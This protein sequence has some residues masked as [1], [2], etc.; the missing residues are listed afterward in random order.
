MLKIKKH[1]SLQPLIDGFKARFADI[2]KNDTRRQ[3][4]VEYSKLDTS[5][6]GLACMFYKSSD[7]LS[8]QERMKK[9]YYKDNLETQFGVSQAPKDNQMRTILG[10][11]DAKAFSPVYKD[12]LNRLQRS[13]ELSKFK[14]GNKYLVALDA[15]QYYSSSKI[16]CS[17]CLTKTDKK[18]NI[19][20]Y[21]HSALQPIICHPDQKQILPMMP[22]DIKN[23]DGSKKQDCEIN[24]AKRLLPKLRNSHPKMDFVWLAD[25]IYATD[26]FISSILEAKEDFIFRIKQGDHKYLYEYIK[27]SEHQSYRYISDKSTIVHHYYQDVPL[28]KSSDIKVNVIKAY[29]I[30]KDK[31][32]KQSSNLIGVWATN[33]QLDDE[34]IYQVTRA[35]RTRWKI[36]NEC[37]NALK[38]NGY[39]LTHNWGHVKGESFAIYNL[40]MLA[41]YIHQILELTDYLF[42]KC[43]EIS[44]TFKNLWTDLNY[45][46]KYYLFESWEHMLCFHLERNEYPP[47]Q[48]V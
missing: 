3:E 17:C 31:D 34:N 36:E 5:L 25:S 26:P 43:R 18:G 28:N 37:F 32:G 24:A 39:E 29:S 9:K 1:L 10:S 40:I 11:I 41:F 47:P 38:N 13:K 4:S 22:E 12:Y 48:I 35:A 19:T 27:T 21:S 44:R 2:D 14:F 33:I 6:A 23:S 15:T 7:M 42:K 20:N 16:S 30:T 46:F 45:H 8:F